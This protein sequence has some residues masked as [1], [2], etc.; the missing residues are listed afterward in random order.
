MVTRNGR[1]S[2]RVAA[3]NPRLPH[4]PFAGT[5]AI[6]ATPL[7]PSVVVVGSYVQDLTW[8]CATF[9]SAGQTIIGTFTTGSGGKGSNQAVAAGRAGAATLFVGAVGDDAFASVAGAFY[10][11]NGIPDPHASENA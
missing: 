5:I 4:H 8:R 1:A 11:E 3:G 9:P 2:L 7:P 10:R 6:M